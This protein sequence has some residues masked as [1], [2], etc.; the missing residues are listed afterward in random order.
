MKMADI[1]EENL[2]RLSEFVASGLGL[3]FPRDRLRDLER[4]IKSAAGELGFENGEACVEW[5][6]SA[7]L[8]RSHIKALAG[9]L[10][11]GETYFFRDS[12]IFQALEEAVF[13]E[14]IQ[15]RRE[16]GKN[17]KIWSAGCSTG[18]E[19]Y[20]IAMLLSGMIPD[21]GGWNITILATD[22][23]V[24]SLRKAAEG[25]YGRWSFRDMSPRIKAKFFNKKDDGRMEVLSTIRKMISFSYLNLAEDTYPSP[26][27]NTTAVDIVFCRNV[28]MYMVPDLAVKVV[29]NFHRCLSDGGYLIVSPCELSGKLFSQFVPLSFPGAMLYRKE[30]NSSEPAEF[31]PCAPSGPDVQ[32]VPDCAYVH[33]FD[34]AVECEAPGVESV[35]EVDAV[36]P[37]VQSL[38]PRVPARDDLYREALASYEAGRYTRAMKES[39]ALL[40]HYPSDAGAM[41][42]VARIH[43]NRGKLAEALEWC[44]KAISTDKL[45]AHSYYLFAT[46]QLEAG[47]TEAATVSL[48][49]ALYLDPNFIAAH[50]ALGNIKRQGRM[51]GECAKYFENALSLLS[52]RDPEDILPESDGVNVGGLTEILRD[53]LRAEA[54]R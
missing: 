11:V 12:K 27:N 17:I 36:Q 44:E 42:L 45:R 1:S 21:P 54:K 37:A 15:E 25:L 30:S 14:L 20:S 22:I 7:P 10:T 34:A 47:Q 29:Q 53:I 51:K 26:F 50:I 43:A 18:E 3:S 40:L 46:I 5:L 48:K 28:L 9:H 31:L 8:E 19:P 13:P 33:G 41:A 49:R 35:Q 38:P 23:N 6:L 16:G 24:R 52:G 39:E 4:G 32:L 2:S